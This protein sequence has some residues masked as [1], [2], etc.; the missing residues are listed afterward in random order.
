MLRC[1]FTFVN[2]FVSA[3]D[4]YNYYEQCETNVIGKDNTERGYT[5]KYDDVF[6]TSQDENDIYVYFTL[7]DVLRGMTIK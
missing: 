4:R 1:I 7:P 5:G 6:I 3:A 2:N